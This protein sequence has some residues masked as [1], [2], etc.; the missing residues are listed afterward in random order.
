MLLASEG[1][2]YE[3]GVIELA[4]SLATPH[5]A[6]VAVLSIARV[7]GSAFGFPNPWLMPSRR[8]LD[9]Q[10]AYVAEAVNRLRARGLAASG[11]VVGTRNAAARIAREAE[12][13]RHDAIVMAADP[14]RSWLAAEFSWSQ[15]PY[16]VRRRARVPVHLV[17]DA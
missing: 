14:P 6:E 4:A 3:R 11:Q 1:R 13:G 10:R 15:E 8:E 9:A 5:A 16:R 12:R 17:V 2:R 7:W